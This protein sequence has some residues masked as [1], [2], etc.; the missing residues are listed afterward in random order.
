MSLT[1]T[2]TMSDGTILTGDCRPHHQIAKDHGLRWSRQLGAWYVPMSRD[3]RP[4]DLSTMVAAFETVGLS[5]EVE[6][7]TTRRT[8]A[9]IE[10]DRADRLEHRQERLERASERV[11][12]ESDARYARYRQD[13]DMIPSGQP[14]LV[15]H[16]SAPRHR[17]AL[18]R[19]DRNMG[20][21]VELS[22]ESDELARRAQ[23]SA[24][25]QSHRESAPVTLRR[26]AKLES[27]IRDIDRRL[28]R[29]LNPET[30]DE[31]R[32]RMNAVRVGLTEQVAYWREHLASLES[33]G[34]KIYGPADFKVGDRIQRPHHGIVERVNAKS[35]TV[36]YDV[37]PQ[38]TRTT[39]YD[40]V[41]PA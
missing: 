35:L 39:K 25:N 6:M 5:V 32:A 33:D 38:F 34:V 24:A 17:K 11:G 30:A 1:L 31:Y 41:V 21:S 36:R 4:R 7:N 9:E 12:A 19:M 3:R 15:D 28:A 40:A 22:R 10:S 13:A 37:M 16:Y 27:E 18:E 26:I 23:A 29:P 20:K 2:H 14:I 8:I